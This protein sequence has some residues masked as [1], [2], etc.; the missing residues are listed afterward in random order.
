LL[1]SYLELCSR[2]LWQRQLM[3]PLWQVFE[4]AEFGFDAE[5]MDGEDLDDE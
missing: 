1:G 2:K 5:E 4:A 3:P